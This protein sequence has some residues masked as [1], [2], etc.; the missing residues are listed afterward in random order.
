MPFCYTFVLIILL[1]VEISIDYYLSYRYNH[2]KGSIIF[3]GA[4]EVN[5]YEVLQN[6]S[7]LPSLIIALVIVGIFLF[8]TI[9]IFFR[10]G[11]I[12]H[13]K[14]DWTYRLPYKIQHNRYR[15]LSR[16][17]Y[18]LICCMYYPIKAL[19]LLMLA[20]DIYA[21]KFLLWDIWKWL[22]RFED[23]T[24]YKKFFYSIY[25]DTYD[26][27]DEYEDYIEDNVSYSSVSVSKP[28]RND[29]PRAIIEY[30]SKIADLWH[31]GNEEMWK[32]ALELYWDRFNADQYRLEKEIESINASDV[33]SLSVHEFYD[34]LYQLYYPWKFTNKLFLSK[35]RK[36]LEK[37]LFDK[38]IDCL[39][40]IQE[41]LFD[42]DFEDIKG[43]LA[44]ASSIHGLGTAGASGLLSILYP[45]HFGTVDKF[46]VYSLLKI[47]GLQEHATV[48]GMNPEALTLNNG[49]VLIEIM[50]NKAQELNERFN[51]D[52]WTPRKIDMILWATRS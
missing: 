45:E 21:I 9:R 4:K 19:F 30:N 52:F 15:G 24:W 46:V 29:T 27:V 18:V 26:N 23:R 28:T 3:W 5:I 12:Q 43:C 42:L 34:F 25:S 1:C 37:Y 31:N 16:P 13:I 20:F 35:N 41:R 33:A 10:E 11:I 51:T 32:D 44:V 36:H 50:R 6:P 7:Y 40:R 49:V 14:D 8:K 17:S 2:Y 48:S 38:E 22:F 47:N 39:A